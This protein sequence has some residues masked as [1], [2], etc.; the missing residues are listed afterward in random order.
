MRAGFVY[1]ALVGLRFNWFEAA[2]YVAQEFAE[3]CVAPYGLQLGS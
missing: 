2:L 3:Y 1:G